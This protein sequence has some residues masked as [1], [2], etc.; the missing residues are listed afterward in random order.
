MRF[1]TWEVGKLDG[2]RTW[3]D[4]DKFRTGYG[5]RRCSVAKLRKVAHLRFLTW[6]VGK[7]EGW[8]RGYIWTIAWGG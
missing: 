7:M 4:M 2:L 3:V 1:L 6:E 8:G 5:V